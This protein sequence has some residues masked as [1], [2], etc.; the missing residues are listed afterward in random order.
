MSSI[1]VVKKSNGVGKYRTFERKNE[2]PA[3]LKQSFLKNLQ[4]GFKTRVVKTELERVKGSNTV[5]IAVYFE[6]HLPGCDPRIAKGRFTRVRRGL[7]RA[8]LKAGNSLKGCQVQQGNR[9]NQRVRMGSWQQLSI[10]EGRCERRLPG[11]GHLNQ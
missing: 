6:L 3:K 9:K 11:V 10:Q 7:P 5:L 1:R 8:I 2:L 4:G